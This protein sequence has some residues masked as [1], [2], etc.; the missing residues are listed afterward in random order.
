MTKSDAFEPSASDPATELDHSVLLAAVDG[1]N[2]LLRSI[3]GLFLSNYPVLMSSIHDA[4]ARNDSKELMRAA[5]TLRGSGGF[6]LTESARN[7]LVDL[8]RMAHDGNL[9]N[10]GERVAELESEMEHTRPEVVRL[11]TE[12][13]PDQ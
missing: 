5:H 4:I 13:L 1:D 9:A 10:A 6:F 11:A 7:K 2:D 8:E 12:G 3:S